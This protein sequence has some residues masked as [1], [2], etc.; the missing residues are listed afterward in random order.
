MENIELNCPSC[1]EQLEIDAAFAG[2]VCRCFNCGS[3]MTVPADP[4]RERDETLTRDDRPDAPGRHPQTSGLD[5]ATSSAPTRPLPSA[6]GSGSSVPEMIRPEAPVSEDV[7]TD[8]T[9]GVDVSSDVQTFTT[10]SGRTVRVEAGAIPTARR[11]RKALRLG[12]YL[13]FAAFVLVVLV[14]VFMAIRM[15]SE[16]PGAG[17]TVEDEQEIQRQLDEAQGRTEVE[18]NP[19]LMSRGNIF[20]VPIEANTAV[21]VD[22]S[23]PATALYPTI[24]MLQAT[25]PNLSDGQALQVIV[26]RESDLVV[27]PEDKPAVLTGEQRDELLALVGPLGP[28]GVAEP[29]EA[30]ERA[31]SGGAT[32]LLLV[33]ASQPGPEAVGAM[34][35]MLDDAEADVKL[36]VVFIGETDSGLEELVATHGGRVLRV[37]DSEVRDWSNE[38]DQRQFEA[39]HN[40]E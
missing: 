12:I 17:G 32:H 5:E 34:R 29:T 8:G 24:K 30:V 4:S 19:Y 6:P 27:F 2:G 11:K 3:L 10:P 22:G 26:Y 20:T 28:L 15:M 9:E 33:T 14:G 23:R 16:Q 25:V 18:R 1:G 21:L 37:R 36:D 40:P 35:G 38:Y 7:A 13:A 31:L 39:A